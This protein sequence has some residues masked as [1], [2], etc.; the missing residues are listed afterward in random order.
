MLE[1]IIYILAIVVAVPEL[2][3]WSLNTLFQLHIEYTMATWFA[4]LVLTSIVVVK[5]GE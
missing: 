1:I 3:I 4:S 2:V 5:F